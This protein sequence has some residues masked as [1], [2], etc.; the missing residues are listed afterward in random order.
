MIRR[1]PSKPTTKIRP[2]LNGSAGSKDR[3]SLGICLDVG[4][5]LNLELLA[6]LIRFQRNEVAWIAGLLARRRGNHLSEKLFVDD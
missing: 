2:V 6:V 3:H 4:P 5:N 1:G